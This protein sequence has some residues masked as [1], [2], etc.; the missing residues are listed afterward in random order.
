[1]ANNTGPNVNGS[2][3]SNN[4]NAAG[5][6]IYQ[7][8]EQD[9]DLY[10]P[11]VY[12]NLLTQ[13]DSLTLN[14][15][16]VGD[17]F[18]PISD[19]FNKPDAKRKLFVVGLIP[20]SATVTG[21]AIDRSNSVAA[22]QTP[23]GQPITLN[24]DQSRDNQVGPGRGPAGAAG[25]CN[26][27]N[28]PGV[29]GSNQGPP[30]VVSLSPAQLGVAIGQAY[31]KQFGHPPTQL[32]LATLVSQSLRET[33]GQW[34]NNNP[35]YIGNIPPGSDRLDNAHT[36]GFVQCNNSVEYYYSYSSPQAGA[37][38][39]VQTV[40]KCG[41]QAAL[42][43]AQNGDF[44]AYAQAL[45]DGNYFTDSVAHYAGFAQDPHSLVGQ[46]GDPNNLNPSI[47][48]KPIQLTPAD[49]IDPATSTNYQQSGSTAAGQAQTQ[50]AIGSNTNLGNTT[51]T[52][53]KFAQAQRD[54]VLK[55]QKLLQDMANT[56][57]L[58]FLVN[59]ASFKV[60]NEKVISQ[61]S[62]TRYG[63]SPVVEHWGDG[64]DKVEGSGKVAAFMAIDAA[65][66]TTGPGLTRTARHYTA[67]YQN[68]LS[69]YQIYR[70]NAGLNVQDA[71]DGN[72]TNLSMLGSIYIYFDHTMYIGSFDEFTVSE[73]D[74][75]PYTLDYSFTFTVRATFLLDQVADPNHTYGIP[76][77]G[78]TT[79]QPP[80]V[81]TT[82]S[83]TLT[84]GAVS[85]GGT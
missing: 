17:Q 18:I 34:P 10:S 21:R 41:G 73:A 23:P 62:W 67:A 9:A 70:N 57:P 79:Q 47:L 40:Y 31:T 20:P 28:V 5:S 24:G 49:S 42:T 80:S 76:R 15:D 61:G 39:F 55:T 59:P 37:T 65:N 58:Q 16:L 63:P 7:Q 44:Q 77:G 35:G 43:A 38:Q 6:L 22:L 4:G 54:M 14:L 56:P 2:A 8:V 72:K 32:E 12:Y 11:E 46:V 66:D 30:V 60:N 26:G 45:H 74:T 78:F 53:Q 68:F 19:S 83:A 52:G 50:R 29:P 85:T 51:T 75:A 64:Q 71:I 33:K 27:K 36:F 69:L 48:P 25:G 13:N 81:P 3:G 82:Q 1:M 84:S